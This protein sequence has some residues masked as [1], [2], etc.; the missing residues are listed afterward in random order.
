[1]VWSLGGP[2]Y[3]ADWVAAPRRICGQGGGAAC[4]AC[5][6]LVGMHLGRF[7]WGESALGIV[8]QVIQ[9]KTQPILLA[10]RGATQ[11]GPT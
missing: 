10:G 4:A 5:C 1:M 9:L 8:T 2:R 11:M 6:G 3:T 7:G